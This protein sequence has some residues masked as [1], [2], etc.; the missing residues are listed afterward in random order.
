MIA[1]TTAG[2]NAGMIAGMIAG[3]GIGTGMIAAGGREIVTTDTQEG[4]TTAVGGR[5]GHARLAGTIAETMNEE[6][7]ITS[8]HSTRQSTLRDYPC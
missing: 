1:G 5:D 6:I 2:M 3:I 8:L 4:A 7:G